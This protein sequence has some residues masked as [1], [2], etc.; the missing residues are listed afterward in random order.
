M[1]MCFGVY[2]CSV[3]FCSLVVQMARD[4]QS[5]FYVYFEVILPVLVE[6]LQVYHHDVSILEQVFSCLSYLFKFL[7]R[8]MLA[9]IKNVYRYDRL[10]QTLIFL[11][12]SFVIWW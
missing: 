7:W 11:S 9:D 8:A 3:E 6:L 4:L 10:R 1:D 5:D 2:N 12:M